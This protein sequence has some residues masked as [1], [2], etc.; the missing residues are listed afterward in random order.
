M[1]QNDMY[2]LTYWH[3]MEPQLTLVAVRQGYY[4]N[5]LVGLVHYLSKLTNIIS[6]YVL[7]TIFDSYYATY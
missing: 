4:Y 2:V 5:K 1:P 6:Y 3:T 7:S